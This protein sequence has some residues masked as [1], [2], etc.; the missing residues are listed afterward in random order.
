MLESQVEGLEQWRSF[1]SPQE[2][3]ERGY[4]VIDTSVGETYVE[5]ILG[6]EYRS[7]G[8]PKY[9]VVTE[10]RLSGGKVKT[11]LLGIHA[12][13]PSN[14]GKGPGTKQPSPKNQVQ[15]ES[16]YEVIDSSVT[17]TF[18]KEILAKE[19]QSFGGPK[20]YVVTEVRQSHGKL[21]RKLDI[22]AM[23]HDNG[24]GLNDYIQE[25]IKK[26][27]AYFNQFVSTLDSKTTRV[28]LKLTSLNQLEVLQIM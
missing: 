8:G 24:M 5:D 3:R 12:A 15:Y 4:E 23:S 16:G 6:K 9:Y 21:R 27:E 28:I 17:E 10:L 7:L 1:V 26:S 11:E 25:A 18:V 2:G 13:M 14:Y 20:Y 22:H 19:S